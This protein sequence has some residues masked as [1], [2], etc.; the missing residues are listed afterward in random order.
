MRTFLFHFKILEDKMVMSSFKLPS[1]RQMIL[2]SLFHR[3]KLED[4]LVKQT[5]I[6]DSMIPI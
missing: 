2:L 4:A 6:L 5:N 3:K 1:L